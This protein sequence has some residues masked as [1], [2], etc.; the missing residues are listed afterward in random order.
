MRLTMLL[1]GCLLATLAGCASTTIAP[2]YN[3]SNPNMKVGGERPADSGPTIEN[4]GSFCMEVTEKWHQDGKTP[5]GQPLWAK[6]S[7]RKVVPCK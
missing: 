3:T 5:D 4:A 7:L 6:D 1:G 2:T